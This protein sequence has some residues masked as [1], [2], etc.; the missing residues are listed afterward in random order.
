M[1]CS[2]DTTV[3]TVDVIV[4]AMDL[5]LDI[6]TLTVDPSCDTDHRLGFQ[7]HDADSGFGACGMRRAGHVGC[8]EQWGMR[9][10]TVGRVG[11]NGGTRGM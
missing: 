1:C 10:V 9:D 7:S 11:C 2:L 5:A 3:L 6:M 4:V 8:D